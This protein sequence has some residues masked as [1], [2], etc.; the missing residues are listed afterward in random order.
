L[1]YR[2]P[3]QAGITHYCSLLAANGGDG[4]QV[5]NNIKAGFEYPQAQALGH[6]FGDGPC[7]AGSAYP[8]TVSQ[9]GNQCKYRY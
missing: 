6:L 1:L 8:W 5:R 7:I 4:W 3:E 9:Q 2:L